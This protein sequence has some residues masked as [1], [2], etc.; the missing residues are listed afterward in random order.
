MVANIVVP[1]GLTASNILLIVCST[2]EASLA[3][4]AGLPGVGSA[5]VVPTAAIAVFP[6]VFAVVPDVLVAPPAD[7][8]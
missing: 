4:I 6:V 2:R 7:G 3:V 5:A 1:A 8:I